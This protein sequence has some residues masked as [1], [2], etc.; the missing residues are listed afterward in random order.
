M[1]NLFSKR[2][3]KH[4]S[5]IQASLLKLP[6]TKDQ[7]YVQ[8]E[9]RNEERTIGFRLFLVFVF[10]YCL[11]ITFAE[12]YPFQGTDWYLFIVVPLGIVLTYLL[13]QRLLVVH[14]GYRTS[15]KYVVRYVDYLKRRIELGLHDAKLLQ[16][17]KQDAQIDANS[18]QSISML[19]NALL[20]VVVALLAVA[21]AQPTSLVFNRLLGVC[22]LVT[23]FSFSYV[24]E[25]VS[26]NTVIL[27]GI[28]RLETHKI[29]SAEK[30][31]K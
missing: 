7:E 1:I 14:T 28:N 27:R 2:T 26:I 6:L 22:M 10:I 8:Q 30:D 16:E 25:R 9:F 20:A 31:N 19:T 4:P 15:D 11:L 24:L 21:A 17:I 12:L 18:T 5:A 13:G 3:S 29:V 23:V